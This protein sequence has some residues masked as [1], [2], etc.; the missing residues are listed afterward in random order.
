MLKVAAAGVSPEPV[1]EAFELKVTPPQPE[2]VTTD[3]AST[4]NAL[5]RTP[6]F[7]SRPRNKYEGVEEKEL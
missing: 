6:S 5:E 7:P 4:A 3:A 1:C 2:N